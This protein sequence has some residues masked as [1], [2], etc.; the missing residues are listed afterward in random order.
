MRQH[1][2]YRGNVKCVKLLERHSTFVYSLS[3]ILRIDPDTH[4][5]S[6]VWDHPTP[7]VAIG[8][9]LSL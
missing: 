9:E 5:I 2:W 4:A 6:V 8:D 7:K 3:D 1:H